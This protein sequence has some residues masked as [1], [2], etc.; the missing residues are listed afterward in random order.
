MLQNQC[1]EFYYARC[2]EKTVSMHV[3][4]AARSMAAMAHRDIGKEKAAAIVQEAAGLYN[5]LWAMHM[6][7]HESI[8]YSRPFIQ[9]THKRAAEYISHGLSCAKLQLTIAETTAYV[10]DAVVPS[11]QRLFALPLA[12]ALITVKERNE[13]DPVV[14][15]LYRDSHDLAIEE[16]LVSWARACYSA[17]PGVYQQVPAQS[18]KKFKIYEL[19]EVPDGSTFTDRSADIR[20]VLNAL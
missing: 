1:V 19:F 10:L 5:P 4:K 15:L 6:Q 16:E 8:E 14:E 7:M 20:S 9:G 13:L 18:R 17:Y 12:T 3:S 11:Q 2:Y